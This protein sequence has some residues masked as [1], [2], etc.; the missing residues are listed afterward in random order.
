MVTNEDSTSEASAIT[1]M[2]CAASVV[3]PHDGSFADQYVRGKGFQKV[4]PGKAGLIEHTL[5]EGPEGTLRPPS[6]LETPVPF[7]TVD[8]SNHTAAFCCHRRNQY[9]NILIIYGSS[10]D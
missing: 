2:G 8:V 4:V 5:P 3:R 9:F 1:T 7:G 10:S 6:T